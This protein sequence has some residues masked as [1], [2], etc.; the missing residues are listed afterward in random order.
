[1]YGG[2]LQHRSY[3]AGSGTVI[4]PIPCRLQR[5]HLIITY[6]PYRFASKRTYRIVQGRIRDNSLRNS[7]P[8][9]PYLHTTNQPGVQ[10]GVTHTYHKQSHTYH[11]LANTQAST[12]TPSHPPHSPPNSPP[13]TTL[14]YHRRLHATASDRGFVVSPRPPQERHDARPPPRGGRLKLQ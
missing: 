8:T 11:A 13:T 2:T 10:K 12:S 14:N 7:I 4:V 1:M 3:Q 5:P 9:H 6:R